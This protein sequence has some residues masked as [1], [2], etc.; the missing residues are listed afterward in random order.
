MAGVKA[1]NKRGFT[2]YVRVWDNSEHNYGQ[3]IAMNRMLDEAVKFGAD[4]FLRLDDDCEP[5]GT[6][7]M[8][9]MVKFMRATFKQ[10]GTTCT[11]S[12]TILGLRNPPVSTGFFQTGKVKAE[13]VEKL[14]GICRLMPMAVMRYFRFEERLPMGFGEANQFASYAKSIKMPL[15]R[16]RDVKVTHGESTDAQEAADPDWAYEHDML[17]LVPYGL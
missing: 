17:Q 10:H 15:L 7:W 16:L 2:T 1:A 9:R 4:S 12:P 3:H 6:D 13:V 11:V 5:D 14:G 8:S